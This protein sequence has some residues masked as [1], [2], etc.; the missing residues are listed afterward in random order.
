MINRKIAVK[1]EESIKAATTVMNRPLLFRPIP[2]GIRA[3]APEKMA[4]GASWGRLIM[5]LNEL[6]KAL[7]AQT[8]RAPARVSPA[9]LVARWLISPENIMAAKDISRITSKSP[10]IKPIHRAG[11]SMEGFKS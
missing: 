6:I 1:K 8:R 9:P 4:T 11:N 5:D 3:A 7:A 2:A 10:R